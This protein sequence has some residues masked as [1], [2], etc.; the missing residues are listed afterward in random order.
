MNSFSIRVPF[1]GESISVF[2]TVS[3]L[4]SYVDFGS[5]KF[6]R[7]SDDSTSF[8]FPITLGA[9]RLL[10]DGECDILDRDLENHVSL[11]SVKSKDRGGKGKLDA[12]VRLS[13][14]DLVDASAIICE[15]G[16][17][18]KGMLARVTLPIQEVMSEKIERVINSIIEESQKSIVIDDLANEEIGF[19]DLSTLIEPM[20]VSEGVD[21]SLVSAM[22]ESG[23]L[24]SESRSRP[25][26]LVLL[27]FP[28]N[29][30]S[31]PFVLLKRIFG[32]TQ[33]I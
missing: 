28:A 10:L 22:V 29:L 8:S 11:I 5:E 27:Q 24:R 25:T 13:L 9:F 32:V 14:E 2:K 15:C 18:A 16:V 26:W 33:G 6:N 19:S 31:F 12:Q 17:T 7:I 1:T 20:V 23:N 21:K 3:D 30:V 4:F